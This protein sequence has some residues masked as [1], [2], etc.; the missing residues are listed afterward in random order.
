MQKLQL[1]V[2]CHKGHHY[3][4]GEISHHQSASFLLDREKR[5]TNCNDEYACEIN[6]PDCQVRKSRPTCFRS[7]MKL[8][9]SLTFSKNML[10]S[11]PS[12]IFPSVLS[13]IVARTTFCF[14]E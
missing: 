6:K 14:N 1:G 2:A 4:P 11:N 12:L 7:M 8:L 5:A 3:L 9:V 13:S 10:H